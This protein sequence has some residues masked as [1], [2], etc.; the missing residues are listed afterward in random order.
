MEHSGSRS[1]WSCVVHAVLTRGLRAT[2]LPNSR[3]LCSQQRGI[4]PVVLV[5]LRKAFPWD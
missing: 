5:L 4:N 2:V 1:L 3:G